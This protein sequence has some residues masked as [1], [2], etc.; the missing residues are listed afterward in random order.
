[1]SNAAEKRERQEAP[2]EVERKFE[3]FGDL[4]D[5]VL[6]AP[7]NELKN[8][9]NALTEEYDRWYRRLRADMDFETENDFSELRDKLA[10]IANEQMQAGAERQMF[11]IPKGREDDKFFAALRSTDADE[12]LSFLDTAKSIPSRFKYEFLERADEWQ[13]RLPDDERFKNIETTIEE[14]VQHFEDDAT[15]RTLAAERQAAEARKKAKERAQ[16]TATPSTPS[17]AP[18]HAGVYDRKELARQAAQTGK[19]KPWWK[20]W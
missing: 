3:S 1:M 20:F 16:K 5:F 19:Q 8:D 10:P 11:W 2:K 17:K 7:A 15:D 9:I 12:F 14:R 18:A 6:N 13:D 4:H